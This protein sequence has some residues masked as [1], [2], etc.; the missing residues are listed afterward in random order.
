MKNRQQPTGEYCFF[1]QLIFIYFYLVIAKYDL[2]G[3]KIL[4]FPL[5]A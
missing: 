1:N 3:K 2:P 5:E 4:F